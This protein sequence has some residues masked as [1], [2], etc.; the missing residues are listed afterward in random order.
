[1]ATLIERPGTASPSHPDTDI[2]VTTVDAIA[3]TPGHLS[4]LEVAQGCINLGKRPI[5]LC[6]RNH[7]FVSAWHR[8]GYQRKYGT[9]AAPC[10]SPG[11]A[12]LERDFPRFAVT[13]LCAMDVV[14]LFG[15]HEGNIGG[16]VSEGRV[17][18]D[19]DP[20]SGRLE[21]LVASI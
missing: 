9:V 16:V 2:A 15:L 13:A 17:V 11:K 4:A 12:P 7:D 14:R 5:A 19:I 18:I 3:A 10:K 8:D 21:S 1:M 6:D 20:R